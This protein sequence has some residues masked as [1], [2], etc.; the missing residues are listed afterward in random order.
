MNF[1]DELDTGDYPELKKI[2]NQVTLFC[3]QFPMPN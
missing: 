2:A 1:K 3:R